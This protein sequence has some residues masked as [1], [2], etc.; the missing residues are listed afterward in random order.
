MK[1]YETLSAVCTDCE[2][3]CS[4][5]EAISTNCTICN[6]SAGRY[7]KVTAD[8]GACLCENGYYDDGSH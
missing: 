5:C 7:L 8:A 3:S 2:Y 4:D 6:V 1:T